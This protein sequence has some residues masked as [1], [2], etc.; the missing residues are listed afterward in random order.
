MLANDTELTDRCRNSA[1]Q[2][3]VLSDGCYSGKIPGA[4]LFEEAGSE[5][6][7]S[8]SPVRVMLKIFFGS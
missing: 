5:M 4:E 3:N 8:R 1:G 6:P 7:L 2:I